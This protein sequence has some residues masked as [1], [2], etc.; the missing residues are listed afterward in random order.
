MLALTSGCATIATQLTPAKC[1]RSELPR[2][3]T[4]HQVYSGT[5]V[6]IIWA[7]AVVTGETGMDAAGRGYELCI[8]PFYFAVEMPLSLI[9][10]TA[11]LPLTIVKQLVFGDVTL[12]VPVPPPGPFVDLQPGM[13]FETREDVL[14]HVISSESSL[15]P[16]SSAPF[17]LDQF[18]NNPSVGMIDEAGIA[19][20]ID[21]IPAGTR[22]QLT[23]CYY[24]SVS[25]LI[26]A[27][28]LTRHG[29]VDI[30]PLLMDDNS[31]RTDRYLKIIEPPSSPT[32]TPP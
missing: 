3:I 7:A 25:A 29:S 14:L 16:A 23:T 17:T 11:L 31:K 13:I 21:I 2:P 20:F 1:R 10:D 6:N 24:S 8:F 32:E 27:P 30:T 26:L 18:R 28:E 5:A 9:A 12:P 15:R 4:V 22:L 19:R